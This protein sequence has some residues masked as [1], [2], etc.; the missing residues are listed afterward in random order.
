MAV[1]GP[2]SR[3]TG[4]CKSNKISHSMID[5]ELRPQKNLIFCCSTIETSS[6]FSPGLFYLSLTFLQK[7]LISLCSGSTRPDMGKC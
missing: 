2:V 3:L 7:H 4:S 6:V 1:P 5:N